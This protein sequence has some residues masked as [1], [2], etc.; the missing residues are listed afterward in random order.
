MTMSD[1]QEPVARQS[2]LRSGPP[3]GSSSDDLLTA[4]QSADDLNISL[5]GLWK[6]VADGRLPQPLYILPRAPRWRRSELRA[7]A[8]K[9]RMRPAEAKLA[10]RN[11]RPRVI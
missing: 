7:A 8:E 1:S 9:N 3:K 10:R 2:S 4:R 5:P 11:N 6:G